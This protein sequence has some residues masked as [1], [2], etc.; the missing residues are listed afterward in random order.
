MPP[1]GK[2]SCALTFQMEKKGLVHLDFHTCLE[3][4]W[5]I[6]SDHQK[7]NNEYFFKTVQVIDLRH[8]PHLY[9]NHDLVCF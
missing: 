8:E 1:Y 2:R 5:T 3:A 4:T 9:S 6:S 7:K